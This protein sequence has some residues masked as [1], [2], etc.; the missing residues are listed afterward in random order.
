MSVLG[1]RRLLVLSLDLFGAKKLG[2]TAPFEPAQDTDVGILDNTNLDKRVVGYKAKIDSKDD[3]MD[4]Y[5]ETSNHK[6]DMPG[7]LA[8]P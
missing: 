8:F 4:A 7:V 1:H 5:L 2:A 3:G 6:L